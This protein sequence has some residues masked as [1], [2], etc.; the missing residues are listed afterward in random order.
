M[1]LGDLRAL[2]ENLGDEVELVVHAGDLE[3]HEVSV[4][5][6]FAATSRQMTAISFV[7]GQVITLEKNLHR[8]LDVKLGMCDHDPEKCKVNHYS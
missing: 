1:T 2:T 5:H 7:M 3:W 4:D 6:I 8:R